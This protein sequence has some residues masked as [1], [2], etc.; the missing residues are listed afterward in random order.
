MIEWSFTRFNKFLDDLTPRDFIYIMTYFSA[1]LYIYNAGSAVKITFKNLM[2][3]FNSLLSGKV[4]IGFGGGGAGARID[5]DTPL[6]EIDF[7][8]LQLSMIAAY[9]LLKIEIDDITSSLAT[10]KGVLSETVKSKLQ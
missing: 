9:G 10:V 2:N 5:P 6:I 8:L 3:Y 4:E 7:G 1:V